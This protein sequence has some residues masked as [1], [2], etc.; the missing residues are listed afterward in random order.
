MAKGENKTDHY[1]LKILETDEYPIQVTAALPIDDLQKWIKHFSDQGVEIMLK[2]WRGDRYMILRKLTEQE[3]EECRNGKWWIS[4]KSFRSQL[5][6]DSQ[7]KK[8]YHEK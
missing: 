4:G 6:D 1:T 7:K 3:K 5:I 2:Q 8:H